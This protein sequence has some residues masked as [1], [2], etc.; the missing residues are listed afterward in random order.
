MHRQE[1]IGFL[2]SLKVLIDS[3]QGPGLALYTLLT[4][5]AYDP[6]TVT[7]SD[8]NAL[9]LANVL[10]RKFN[11]ELHQD[12]E[13][14]PE[15]VLKV[16]A[17]LDQDAVEFARDL[18]D[19]DRE[20]FFL[21]FRHIHAAL[22][23]VLDENP[24]VTVPIRYLFTL[25]REVYMLFALVGGVTGQAVLR[26]GLAEYGDPESGIYELALSQQEMS[27]LLQILNVIVRALGRIGDASDAVL[28]HEIRPRMTRLINMSQE[29]RHKDQ[30][31]RLMKWVEESAAE[32]SK[33]SKE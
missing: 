29:Q 26:S 7:F 18:I 21:K 15:E 13:M 5:F 19:K 17:G 3:M 6:E 2:N 24:R 32:I 14:T 20:R 25:E 16:K 23:E 12:I 9:M 10:L 30:V 33:R 4:D 28:L 8:R 1:R 22:R 27:W 31:R 11:K